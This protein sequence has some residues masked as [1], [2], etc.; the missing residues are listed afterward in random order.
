MICLL[1]TS[2][3]R[4]FNLPVTGEVDEAT[5]YKIGYLYTGVKRLSELDSE[6]LSFDETAQQYP[7][8]LQLG[9]TGNPVRVLQYY[10]AVILSL[11]HIS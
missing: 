11:I 6:G 9:D 3:Q 8:I 5:W 1:Y 10:L 7:S 4:V 2:F